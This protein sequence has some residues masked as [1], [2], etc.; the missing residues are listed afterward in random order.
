MSFSSSEKQGMG[1]RPQVFRTLPK[2]NPVAFHMI[3][4]WKSLLAHCAVWA[5]AR[6][7]STGEIDHFFMVSIMLRPGFC[8]VPQS[9]IFKI[10]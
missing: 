8:D 3:F 4:R 6:Q 2:E 5:L 7:R 10:C 9:K 1:A